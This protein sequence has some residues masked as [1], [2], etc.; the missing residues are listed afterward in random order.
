LEVVE[1][2]GEPGWAAIVPFYNVYEI[3]KITWGSGW[4]FLLLLIP[5]ANYVILIITQVKLAKAFGKG[6]GFACGLIFLSPIFMLILAFGDARYVG[7]NGYNPNGYNPNMQGGYNPNGYNPNMQGGYNPNGYNPNM[8]GGYNPN[9]NYDPNMQ[10][11]GYGQN[12]GYTN[13]MQ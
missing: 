7:P 1:K 6:G 13:G 10:N 3:Y 8:Q 12:D 9:N 4:Y 2:A 5:F 11:N